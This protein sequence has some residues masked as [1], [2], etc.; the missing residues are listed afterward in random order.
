MHTLQ[1]RLLE[2]ALPTPAGLSRKKILL[3]TEIL[4]YGPPGGGRK[5]HSQPQ[6]PQGRLK[7]T[8]QEAPCEWSSKTNPDAPTEAG[9]QGKNAF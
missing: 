5:E 8:L 7:V 6:T 9:K 3:C 4:F 1:W 2:P